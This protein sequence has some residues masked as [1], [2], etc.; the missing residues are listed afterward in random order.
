MNRVV[1]AGDSVFDNAPYVEGPDVCAQVEAKLPAG[2]SVSMLAIDGSFIPDVP[3]QLARLPGDAE[4]LVVSAGGNDVLSQAGR[5]NDAV[6]SVGEALLQLEGVVDQ[7]RAEYGQLLDAVVRCG[8]R[9]VVCTIY[10]PNFPDGDFQR[11]TSTAL[12]LFNDVIIEEAAHRQ[13]PILDI[14]AIFTEVGDYA[15]PIE[16]SVQGGAKLADAIVGLAGNI[17]GG[18]NRGS[19]IV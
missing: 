1:L 6:G 10:R 12:G 11:I 8:V 15:N 19:F 2:W 3:A 17:G 7:F 14:R 4:V 13:L 9:S 18:L 5:L 16:P